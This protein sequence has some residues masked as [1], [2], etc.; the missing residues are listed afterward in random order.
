MTE[1]THHSMHGLPG[2]PCHELY[3][4][5]F[6]SEA[7]LLEYRLRQR[8]HGARLSREQAMRAVRDLPSSMFA[9]HPESYLR[10]SDVEA[11]LSEVVHDNDD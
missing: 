6:R 4:R 3:A 2:H 9:G 5:C 11:I 7:E 1:Q 10:R 8:A